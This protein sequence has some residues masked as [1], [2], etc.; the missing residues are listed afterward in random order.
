[1]QK[2][3]VA[4]VRMIG[5]GAASP[6]LDRESEMNVCDVIVCKK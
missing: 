6:V 5:L 2:S 3:I 1:M 4:Q